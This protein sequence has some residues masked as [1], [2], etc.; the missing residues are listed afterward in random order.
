MLDFTPPTIEYAEAV[1]RR[2]MEIAEAHR[3]VKALP[4]KSNIN[5]LQRIMNFFRSMLSKIDDS[6]L[7][8]ADLPQQELI[9]QTQNH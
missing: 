8:Q 1:H 9:Q 5:I 6:E 2:D 3:Q 7:E 4:K